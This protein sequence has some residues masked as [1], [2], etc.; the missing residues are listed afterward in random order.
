[1]KELKW[2]GLGLAMASLTG[3][4]SGGSFPYVTA[5]ER[6]LRRLPAN[7]RRIAARP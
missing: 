3:P 5:E 7:L 4:A 6:A 2:M 1:M